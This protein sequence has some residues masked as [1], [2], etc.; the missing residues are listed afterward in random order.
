MKFW[1]VIS[2]TD[3]DQSIVLAQRA[4]EL[5]YEGVSLGDHLVTFQSQYEHYQY[6]D[7]GKVLWNPETH[8]PD[9]WVH[10]GAM[11][12]LTT[13]LKFLPQVYVLPMRDPFN[14]AKAISTAAK[15][16][17]NRVAMGVGVGWQ[18]TEFDILG[19]SFGNRGKRSDEMLEIMAE[20]M[21]GDIVEY[22]GEYY[23]FEP[24]Q[25]SPGVSQPVPVY[26]GGYSSAAFKRAAR[27]DGWIGGQNTVEELGPIIEALNQARME[28]GKN[29]G[30]FEIM[31]DILN[32]NSDNFK[33]AEDMGVTA[34]MKHAWL[35]EKGRVS[36]M[37]LDQKLKDMEEF[38]E[39]YLN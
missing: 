21:S 2:M 25:M 12:Q 35:T 11:S 34:V 20:L 37:S 8:W 15:L 32:P 31:T 38:A 39:R 7:D 24:L 26:I 28:Q 13:N 23:N 6:S 36:V 4:E 19:Q 9:P 3:M 22:S 16:S 10:I 17:N 30:H 5:G 33:Q 29:K 14:A 18:K 1:Q 27:H